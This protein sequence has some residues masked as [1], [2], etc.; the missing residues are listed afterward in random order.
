VVELQPSKLA[1][2]VQFPSPA[3]KILLG[4]IFVHRFSNFVF[5]IIEIR[6]TTNDIRRGD[7]VGAFAEV[8]QS[9]EHMHGKHEV[10]GSI[11]ILGS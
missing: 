5:R 7:E 4:K 3:Q 8:A 9:V 10:V 11:P 2:R 1:T 6:T